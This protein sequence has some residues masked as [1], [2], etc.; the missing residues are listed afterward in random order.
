MLID[1]M[2]RY[3]DKMQYSTISGTTVG[4]LKQLTV[5]RMVEGWNHLF[6]YMSGA[7]AGKTQKLA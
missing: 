2:A 7:W 6:T 3:S 5:T 4:G 1:C